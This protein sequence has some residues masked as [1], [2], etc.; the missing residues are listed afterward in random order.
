MNLPVSSRMTLATGLRLCIGAA[1][2]AFGAAQAR[3]QD[4]HA[5]AHASP[6]GTTFS[7]V[8]LGVG[9]A[10]VPVVNNQ[11]QVAFTSRRSAPHRAKFYDGKVVLDLGD[12]GFPWVDVTGINDAGQVSGIADY[13]PS[14]SYDYP[15]AFRWSRQTGMVDL[16]ALPNHEKSQSA[17]I[18]ASGQVAGV[19]AARAGLDP[20]AV[21]AVRW[22][23][24]SG[25]LDLGAGKTTS[26]AVDINDAGSI[27]AGIGAAV[28]LP[29]HTE[30]AA[31]WTAERGL[32]HLGTLGGARSHTV[33][34]NEPGQI[35]GNAQ[36]ANGELHAFFWTPGA[37]L[38]DL[39]TLG[40][41]E[42]LATALNDGGRVA[43][44]ST[45]AG[46][47]SHAFCWS[48]EE[49][50]RDLG[51]LGG[52]TSRAA[53][54]NR[55]DQ[56]VGRSALPDGADRA[57]LWTRK[58]G[59]TDLNS[60]IP[61]A[62][63]GLIVH[64]A[65]GVSDQGHIV[66]MSNAGLVL[67]TPDAPR[68]AAPVGGPVLLAA[69]VRAREP[70]PVS[71]KFV[72]ANAG[73]S[74]RATWSWGDGTPDQPATVDERNG[75]GRIFGQHAYAQQ[76]SYNIML[77]ITDSSGRLAYGTRTVTVCDPPNGFPCDAPAP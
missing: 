18:N 47:A 27:A 46:G 65:V 44:S 73:D 74:H 8:N 67:L 24:E 21:H 43:G 31:V 3:Q 15:H 5:D 36:L 75:S 23:V 53:D 70:E 41:S 60:R 28:D 64:D 69:P 32:V 11:G 6:S 30:V 35:A 55:R 2:A 7:V 29:I 58:H 71:V 4:I 39:G 13:R 72:D 40:G 10:L 9:D 38:V 57:F 22:T 49:G 48:H 42:S 76:G 61:V 1:L 26:F 50:M 54:I 14:D 45:T 68:L 52:L 77:T 34:I 56:V 19:S 37:R 59:M 63:S 16:G 12:F 17:A 51:T 25:I 20:G 62:P 33:A 66:A